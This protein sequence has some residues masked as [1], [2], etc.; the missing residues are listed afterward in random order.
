MKIDDPL[1][2]KGAH[3][4]AVKWSTLRALQVLHWRNMKK[5]ENTRDQM[6]TMSSKIHP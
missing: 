5:L 2:A 6:T 3:T 1:I 4:I